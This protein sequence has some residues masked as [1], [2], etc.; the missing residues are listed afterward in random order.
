MLTISMTSL[1]GRPIWLPTTRLQNIRMTSNRHGYAALDFFVPMER[2]LALA[3]QE[4]GQAA[5]VLVTGQG[6]RR[7]WRG[8]VEDLRMAE[9]G[10]RVGAFGYSR[11]Y[12]DLR[13]TGLWSNTGSG[14]WRPVLETELSFA[15]AGRYEM[16]NNNRLNIEL[17]Q[18][19]SS[20]TDFRGVMVWELPDKGVRTASQFLFDYTITGVVSNAY[21]LIVRGYNDS[22]TQTSTSTVAS[23][24]SSTSGSATVTLGANTTKVAVLFSRNSGTPHTHTGATGDIYARL[25]NLRI[26][27]VAG[28]VLGSGIV[29]AMAAHV[30]ATNP[31]QVSTSAAFVTATTQDLRDEV[32][33]DL[34]HADILDR[35]AAIHEFDWAVWE[36]KR[37]RFAPRGQ[38]GQRYVV[39]AVRVEIEQSLEPM[40]NRAYALYKSQGGRTLRTA[41]AQNLE[42]VARLGLVREGVVRA[43]T[44]SATEAAFWRDSFLEDRGRY[45]MRA[46]V[47][48]ERIFTETG[49]IVPNYEPRAGDVLTIRNLMPTGNVELDFVRSF[50]MAATAYD[51]EGDELRV[52]PDVPTPTLV[53]LVA[54]RGAGL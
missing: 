11:A 23:T 9:G 44:T 46:E 21:V 33:E 24:T 7:V 43:E 20:S 38:G 32:Y 27:S 19:E 15:A 3:L 17:K 42:G 36:D 5:D 47:V 45:A 49:A 34:P 41:T 29:A 40:S 18:N 12:R 54:R 52:E 8:R 35:M 4:T 10:V 16:D 37:L 51:V 25:T 13:Y 22:W 39:D 30:A 26:R 1:A 50:R 28:N 14:G 48:F 31:S 53:T 2:A 6:G